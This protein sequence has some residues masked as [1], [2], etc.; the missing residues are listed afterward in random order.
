MRGLRLTEGI[1]TKG[2]R[3]YSSTGGEDSD[4]SLRLMGRI[5]DGIQKSLSALTTKDYRTNRRNAGWEQASAP[6]PF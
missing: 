4:D 3:L 1:V 6:A 2:T 5:G